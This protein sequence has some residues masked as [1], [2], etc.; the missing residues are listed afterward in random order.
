MK[1]EYHTKQ[2]ELLISFV[3]NNKQT[4][5]TANEIASAL[6]KE[7]GIGKSTVYR[8][9]T[10]LTDDGVLKRFYDEGKKSAVY[11]YV[12]HESGCDRHFHLKCTDCGK[13]VHLEDK[14]TEAA[15]KSI[16]L[17]NQF[18]MDEGKT[19]LFGKCKGCKEED[20]RL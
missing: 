6:C 4:A 16:L 17:D 14:T 9:V 12:D 8:L 7:N 19:I 10:K 15:L 20:R 11:Q 5:F 1:N 18:V 13:T 2:R 3:K